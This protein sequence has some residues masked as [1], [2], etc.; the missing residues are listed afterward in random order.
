MES[1]SD[2]RRVSWLFVVIGFQAYNEMSRLI[3][4]VKVDLVGSMSASIR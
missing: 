4:G 3:V 2:G 1:I